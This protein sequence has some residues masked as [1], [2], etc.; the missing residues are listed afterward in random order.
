MF[1]FFNHNLS[2][3]AVPT[4]IVKAAWYSQNGVSRGFRVSKKSQSC[5]LIPLVYYVYLIIVQNFEIFLVHYNN[6]HLLDCVRL[7]GLNHVLWTTFFIL[8]VF[9]FDLHFSSLIIKTQQ[10]Y[11]RE[12][13]I[14]TLS[15]KIDLPS[16][17]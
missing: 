3:V 4:G 2:I 7:D 5:T 8:R 10:K 9:F 6:D 13:K 14:K 17:V 11:L 15:Q 12:K 16:Y 1:V